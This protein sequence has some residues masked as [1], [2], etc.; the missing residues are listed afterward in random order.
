MVSQA[1]LSHVR[2]VLKH[3]PDLADQV[4]AQPI[5]L[6]ATRMFSRTAASKPSGIVSYRSAEFCG[7]LRSRS[8]R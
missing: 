5:A 4:L 2:T 1:S 7:R 8:R 3:A 6:S